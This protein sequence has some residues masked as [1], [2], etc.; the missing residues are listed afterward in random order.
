LAYNL[1]IDFTLQSRWKKS[2]NIEKFIK[3]MLL[4]DKDLIYFR[5]NSYIWKDESISEILLLET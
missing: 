4:T 5:D 2:E 1:K 3:K